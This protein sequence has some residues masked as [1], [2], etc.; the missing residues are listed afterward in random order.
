MVAPVA[1]YSFCFVP[2]I[3]LEPTAVLF[4]IMYQYVAWKPHPSAL[5]GI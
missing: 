1:A 5:V 2:I 3:T 4:H